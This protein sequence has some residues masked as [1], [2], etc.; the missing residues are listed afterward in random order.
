MQGLGEGAEIAHRFQCTRTMGHTAE[1]AAQRRGESV[2]S[3]PSGSAQQQDEGEE[4]G[5]EP[6]A[7]ARRAGEHAADAAT[8]EADIEGSRLSTVRVAVLSAGCGSEEGA[9]TLA[10]KRRLAWPRAGVTV[11]VKASLGPR[12]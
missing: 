3:R 9:P 2:F 5:T 12:S 6:A 1:G 10:A 8:G 11:A 4:A 7:A